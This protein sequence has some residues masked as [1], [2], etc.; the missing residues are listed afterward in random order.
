M[1]NISLDWKTDPL[2]YINFFPLL[3][4]TLTINK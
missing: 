1:N 3:V 4:S 2:I